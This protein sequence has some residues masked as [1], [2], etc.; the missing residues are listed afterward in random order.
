MKPSELIGA[1]E[2]SYG[3]ELPERWGRFLRDGEFRGLRLLELQKGY[4]RG[5]FVPRFTG[6]SLC[7]LAEI[8]AEYWIDDIEDI[9]WGE[10]FAD[11][12]PFATLDD[13]DPEPGSEGWE[14]SRAFLV[15]QVSDPECPVWVWN[16]DG[17]MIYPLAASLDDFV[18]GTAWRAKTPLPHDRFG[19]MRYQ[20][21]AWT[22]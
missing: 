19:G 7:D 14:P 13:P 10:E 12:V 17:W 20:S 4:L 11:F 15:V 21:F 2:S 16:Y 18:A 22:K 5:R 3:V 6:S 8:G 9:D 1:L